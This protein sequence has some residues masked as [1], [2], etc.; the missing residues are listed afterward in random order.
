VWKL[1]TGTFWNAKQLLK[2]FIDKNPILWSEELGE[3]ISD[4]KESGAAK[5]RLGVF[6]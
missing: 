6:R 2:A 4:S 5:R 1:W 3:Y